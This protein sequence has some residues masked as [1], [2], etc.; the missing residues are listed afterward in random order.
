MRDA[1]PAEGQSFRKKE[2]GGEKGG[3]PA[4]GAAK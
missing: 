1:P 2:C 4:E 3:V